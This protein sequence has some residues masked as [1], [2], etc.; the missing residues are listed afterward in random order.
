MSNQ[1][2]IC[3]NKT[4]DEGCAYI[5]VLSGNG[6]S[7]VYYDYELNLEDNLQA[8]AENVAAD[9]FGYNSVTDS[10]YEAHFRAYTKVFI[11]EPKQ[12]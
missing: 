12:G 3:E 7:K 10:F 5:E 1:A 6:L 2:F 4:D 11:Y 8:A 9:E